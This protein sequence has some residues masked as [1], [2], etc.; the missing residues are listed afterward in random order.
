MINTNNKINNKTFIKLNFK[1]FKPLIKILPN[2]T[3]RLSGFTAS[4][5]IKKKN[6]L[7]YLKILKNS[8]GYLIQYLVDIAVLDYP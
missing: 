3:L 6:L 1:T 2:I 8:S 7:M 5:S 4:I